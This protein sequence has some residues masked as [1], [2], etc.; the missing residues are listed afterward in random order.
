M[1]IIL[2]KVGMKRV[3]S[4]EKNNWKLNWFEHGICNYIANGYSLFA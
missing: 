1:I 3:A 4:R 2:K